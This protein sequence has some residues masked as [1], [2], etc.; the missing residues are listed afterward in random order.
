MLPTLFAG[1]IS[2]QIV[3][4]RDAQLVCERSYDFGG[5]RYWTLEKRPEIA[6]GGQLQR[7]A[8]AVVFAATAADLCKI[9]VVEMKE[10][11]QL[12]RRRRRRV[13]TVVLALRGREKKLIGIPVPTLDSRGPFSH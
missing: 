3:Q 5:N 9:F 11:A 7:E 10:P 4:F 6:H 12:V 1:P 13:A 8:E 2:G